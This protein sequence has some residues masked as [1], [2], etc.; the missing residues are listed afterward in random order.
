MNFDLDSFAKKLGWSVA[1]VTSPDLPEKTLEHYEHW[2]KEYR[3]PQMMN[4]LARRK[5]ERVSPK[6]YFPEVQSVL[7]FGLFY[8]PGWAEGEVKISN[9]SWGRDYHHLLKE[10]LEQTAASLQQKLG[11]FTY[12]ICVDT[13][14]IHE[15]AFA[16]EAGLGWQGKNTL[17]LN[18]KFGSFLFLGE[19][20]TAL[21]LSIFE[22]PPLQS[23]HCG[24][25]QR[26]LEACPTQAL[27]PYVLDARK[28]I[29]YWT[30]EHRGSFTSETPPFA[31][32]IAGC[33]ICQEVCPWNQK[34]IPIIESDEKKESFSLQN[35]K[36]S[37]VQDSHWPEKI[38][39]RAVSY[40]PLENWARNL[41]HASPRKNND[42]LK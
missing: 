36:L 27:G 18:S 3:G 10:K 40:V 12:R 24:S 34:L 11:E 22:T 5:E 17:L 20:L 8:F 15:K 4:Y 21:P 26:C 28:C 19:I 32:W 42:S 6:K 37:E 41:E 23:D 39:D 35:I 7:C 9:Y 29:S 16:V 38:K 13:S 25:C 2:L 30:L 1:G 14:P 33:D 31:E